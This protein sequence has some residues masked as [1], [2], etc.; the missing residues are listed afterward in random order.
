MV[1]PGGKL[2]YQL[3]RLHYPISRDSTVPKEVYDQLKAMPRPKLGD[4]KVGG[5]KKTFQ[6]GKARHGRRAAW[7]SAGHGAP[8]TRPRRAPSPAQRL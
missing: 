4:Y 1:E 8:C 2:G 7:T 5:E 3:Y 6:N